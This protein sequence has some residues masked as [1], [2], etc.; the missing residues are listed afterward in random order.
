VGWPVNH[1]MLLIAL[2]F[3]GFMAAV[4]ACLYLFNKLLD[5]IEVEHYHEEPFK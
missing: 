3:A 2:V 4:G 1:F 5:Q